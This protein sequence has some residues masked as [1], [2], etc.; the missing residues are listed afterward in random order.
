MQIL[1]VRKR[2]YLFFTLL[3]SLILTGCEESE[4][5]GFVDTVL[6]DYVAQKDLGRCQNEP[7]R[8][9][10]PYHPW[11]ITRIADAIL[12]TPKQE[13]SPI[14]NCIPDL[15]PDVVKQLTPEQIAKNRNEF[16]RVISPVQYTIADEFEKK[17]GALIRINRTFLDLQELVRQGEELA[18]IELNLTDYYSNEIKRYTF[19]EDN[20]YYQRLKQLAQQGDADAMC[21]YATRS[22]EPLKGYEHLQGA[23]FQKLYQDG[24]EDKWANG[25]IKAAKQGSVRCLYDYSR[26]LVEKESNSVTVDYNP[27]LGFELLKEAAYKGS[28]AAAG[29]LAFIYSTKDNDYGVEGGLCEKVVLGR[30]S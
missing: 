27:K 23:S 30:S 21:H 3:F 1:S 28:V 25:I 12:I 4:V 19:T 5:N 26:M 24:P 18:Q 15:N 20:P 16:A 11:F 22:P 13:G 9:V 7:G 2:F 6:K 8:L 29:T 14:E 17:S 10:Q